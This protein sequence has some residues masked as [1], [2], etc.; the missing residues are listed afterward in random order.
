[1]AV[2][3]AQ[4]TRPAGTYTSPEVQAPARGIDEAT[5]FRITVDLSNANLNDPTLTIDMFIDGWIDGPEWIVCAAATG[6]QG[7]QTGRDGTPRP[8]TLGWVASDNRLLTKARVRWA[9]NQ[10]AR[11]GV[12][13]TLDK[14]DVLRTRAR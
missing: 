7:G 4:Q 1:M 3:V 2:L 10:T 12:S 11:S 6:W 5:K 8:P 9:Q 13:A 14:V